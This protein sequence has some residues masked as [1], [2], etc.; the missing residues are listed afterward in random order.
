MHSP[1]SGGRG[2]T[3]QATLLCLSSGFCVK[4]IPLFQT[5]T[6]QT[7]KI[8]FARCV[9]KNRHMPEFLFPGLTLELYLEEDEYLPELTESAGFRLSATP[10]NTMPFPQDDSVLVSPGELTFISVTMVTATR[11]RRVLKRPFVPTECV[12]TAYV[13]VF[14][15][16]H[17]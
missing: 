13:C 3:R 2:H 1:G 16:E 9:F 5:N 11:L 8:D 7:W 4:S 15:V 17:H 6:S 12:L 14:S 10:Q